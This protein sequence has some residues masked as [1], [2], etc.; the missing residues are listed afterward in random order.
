MKVKGLDNEMRSE[1]E[2]V[3]LIP[4]AG[5]GELPTGDDVVTG[6]RTRYNLY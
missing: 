3:A 2:D 4:R 6:M 5:P 1:F